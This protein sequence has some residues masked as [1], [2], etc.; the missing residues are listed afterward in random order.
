MDSDI[1]TTTE[2]NEWV[3]R[4]NNKMLAVHDTESNRRWR[5][6]EIEEVRR[7]TGEDLITSEI[8]VDV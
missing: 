3:S 6:R 5:V 8:N 7:I 4:T 1:W 2:A